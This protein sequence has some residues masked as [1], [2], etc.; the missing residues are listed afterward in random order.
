MGTPLEFN[1]ATHC[2]NFHV[3]DRREAW[4]ELFLLF[5]AFYEIPSQVLCAVDCWWSLL[6]RFGSILLV[7]L[8]KICL[9]RIFLGGVFLFGI[10]KEVCLHKVGLPFWGRGPAGDRRDCRSGVDFCSV[11]FL[12]E[13]IF[14]VDFPDLF[15]LVSVRSLIFW[16]AI[17]QVCDLCMTMI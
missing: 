4:G 8:R 11:L 16:G 1:A 3:S 2:V 12:L 10:P 14:A 17:L 6:P 5:M 9:D 15:V 7:D 13:F